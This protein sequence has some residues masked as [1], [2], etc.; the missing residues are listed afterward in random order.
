MWYNCEVVQ[1]KE[2]TF[3]SI[4]AQMILGELVSA[5]VKYAEKKIVGTG[6][7]S[8]KKQYVIDKV[9]SVMASDEAQ[10][11]KIDIS[12]FV[13]DKIEAAVTKLKLKK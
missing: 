6:K 4:F 1:Q 12:K 10:E 2:L 3:M 8:E 5:L 13:G 9:N 11:I 7:G